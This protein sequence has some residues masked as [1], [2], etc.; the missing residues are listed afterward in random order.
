MPRPV[1]P[2]ELQALLTPDGKK[3]KR[4][5]V[6]MRAFTDTENNIYINFCGLR[7][8]NKWQGVKFIAS[9]VIG[10]TDKNIEFADEL[11]TALI[12]D[13]PNK[14][15]T[16][17]GHSMGASFAS[18]CGIKNNLD[19]IN[20]NGLGL[21]THHIKKLKNQGHQNTRTIHIN[22]NKDWLSQKMH[23]F[24]LIQ[25]GER[26][27]IES[28]SGHAVVTENQDYLAEELCT[29]SNRMENVQ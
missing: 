26:Y 10:R 5:A 29:I 1:Y 19:T 14:K 16:L 9:L 6:E 4:G 13:N 7:G 24:F 20:F 2:K 11:V 25:P 12:K 28:F 3:I 18:Y 17:V 8:N 27:F 15:I 22:T 23:N 21:S